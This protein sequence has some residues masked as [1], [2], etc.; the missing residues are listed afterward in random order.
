MLIRKNL[1]I[2]LKFIG[3][4]RL[5][6]LQK[7]ITALDNA[8]SDTSSFDIQLTKGVCLPSHK[9]HALACAIQNNSDLTDLHEAIESEMSHSGLTQPDRKK[10]NPHITVARVKKQNTLT[11]EEISAIENW[12]VHSIWHSDKVMLFESKLSPTGPSYTELQ[13]IHLT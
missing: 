11:T 4:T 7:I 12:K 13:T 9:P 10:Y 8:V 5:D 2:T 6:D 3:D 1:H